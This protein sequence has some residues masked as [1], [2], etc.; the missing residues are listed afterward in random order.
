MPD[1]ET[2]DNLSDEWRPGSSCDCGYWLFAEGA[3]DP[4]HG[5]V[6]TCRHHS[7]SKVY[8]RN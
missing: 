2:L 6:F 3:H 4:R 8:V 5:R 7:N 1:T